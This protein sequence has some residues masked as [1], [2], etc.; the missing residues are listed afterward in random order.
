[1]ELKTFWAKTSNGKPNGKIV[2]SVV[3]HSLYTGYVAHASL[4]YIPKVVKE[5][6]IPNILIEKNYL[7]LF[8]ALHDIGKISPFQLKSSV[9]KD[10]CK[11]TLDGLPT[12]YKEDKQYSHCH[13]TYYFFTKELKLGHNIATLIA[14][15]HGE[16]VEDCLNLSEHEGSPFAQGR[17][18]LYELCAKNFGIKTDQIFSDLRS[19]AITS[20]L[21]K[22]EVQRFI[23]GWITIV[24]WIASNEQFFP[25]NKSLTPLEMAEKAK[26]AVDSLYEIRKKEIVSSLSFQQLF[27][28]NSIF[29]WKPNSFQMLTKQMVTKPD[30][31]ILEAPMGEG[32]TEAAL[33]ASYA[34]IQKNCNEGIYFALPTRLTSNHM[35]KRIERFIQKLYPYPSI[36]VHLVHKNAWME[37]P[38]AYIPDDQ[39]LDKFVCEINRFSWFMPKKRALLFPYGVGTI[40]QLLLAVLMTKHYAVRYFGLS[41]KVVILDEIHSYDMYTSELIQNLIEDLRNLQCTVLILSATLTKEKKQMLLGS[42]KENCISYVNTSSVSTKKVRIFFKTFPPEL[43]SK[44]SL[45][46]EQRLW[47]KIATMCLEKIDQGYRILWVVN[48]V[49]KAQKIFDLIQSEKRENQSIGLLHSRFPHWRR[50][51]LEKEYLPFFEKNRQFSSEGFLLISTQIVEQS[52]DIDSDFLISELAPT[53]QILQRL[54][55]LWRHSDQ[56]RPLNSECEAWIYS[57]D[58][59]RLEEIAE[60]KSVECHFQGTQ[61]IYPTYLLYRTWKVWQSRYQVSTADKNNIIFKLPNDMSSLLEETYSFLENKTLLEKLFHQKYEKKCKKQLSE[62]RDKLSKTILDKESKSKNC[63]TRWNEVEKV[64]LLLVRDIEEIEKNKIKILPLFGDEFILE[65]YSYHDAAHTLILKNLVSLPI[66]ILCNEDLQIQ[67]L[68]NLKKSYFGE[69]FYVG[70]VTE[71]NYVCIENLQISLKWSPKKGIEKV[72]DIRRSIDESDE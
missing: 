24:D 3:D 37:K 36:K 17:L 64:N 30:I 20:K 21:K 25:L 41:G 58:I 18:D 49:Q 19:S 72:T 53:D 4:K 27:S 9:W 1:M 65:K 31:Y 16:D 26:F 13:Y 46:S 10:Y 45:E 39:S 55:R 35:H 71:K 29:E 12:Y 57:L 33:E 62:A 2:L 28:E 51:E 61:Y 6:L 69:I 38:L 70:K 68:K 43:E 23:K 47:K 56:K 59:D 15:H 66:T 48:T 14:S 60:K 50:E 8:A 32:K 63:S 11:K 22:S 34:L 52:L 44:N 42:K 40:D 7:I 54:G 5:N 67:E